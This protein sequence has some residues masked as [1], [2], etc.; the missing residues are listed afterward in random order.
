MFSRQTYAARLIKQSLL[1]LFALL[2]ISCK[3][4]FPKVELCGYHEFSGK[5]VCNDKRKTPNEYERTIKNGDLVTSPESFERARVFCAEM[6]RDL[7]K[8][9]RRARR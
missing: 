9:E 3:K 5:L 8:C 7:V 1:V 4:D 6:V 2:I